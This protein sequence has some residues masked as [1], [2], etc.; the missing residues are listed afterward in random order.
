MLAGQALLNRSFISINSLIPCDFA[1]LENKIPARTK[2]SSSF[3]L[4]S[5]L[6]GGV[7]LLSE[8]FERATF[9]IRQYQRAGLVQR[10]AAVADK[11]DGFCFYQAVARWLQG[12][13]VL[14]VLV[15]FKY[16]LTVIG[17]V[18]ASHLMNT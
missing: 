9:A 16:Q 10:I 8:R 3:E 13:H 7:G 18:P 12:R 4:N 15:V 14:I 2:V 17:S 5:L 1:W 11:G 6:A